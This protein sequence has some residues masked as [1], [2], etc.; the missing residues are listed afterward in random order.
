MEGAVRS[1]RLAAEAVAASAGNPTRFL[2]AEPVAT[3]LM[4]WIAK[5]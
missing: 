3:G 2:A 5:R 4:K 1:G